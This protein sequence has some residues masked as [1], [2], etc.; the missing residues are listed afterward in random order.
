MSDRFQMVNDT[1]KCGQCG[2]GHAVIQDMVTGKREWMFGHDDTEEVKS[3]TLYFMNLGAEKA[4]GGPKQDPPADELKQ[5]SEDI[6]LAE[7][8][9]KKVLARVTKR[10]AAVLM[11]W[12]ELGNQVPDL[13]DQ[14][15]RYGEFLGKDAELDGKLGEQLGYQGCDTGKAYILVAEGRSLWQSRKAKAAK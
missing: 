14:M 15:E 6:Y 2:Q 10:L 9:A 5:T 13:F 1:M 3:N 7:S 4:A 8:T 11:D 12:S